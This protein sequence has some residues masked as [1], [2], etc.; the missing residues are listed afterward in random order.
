[1][2]LAT[3]GAGG[4]P[5]VRF[6]HFKGLRAN[7]FVFYTN[8]GSRKALELAANPAAA[9]AFCWLPLRRQVR[10]EGRCLQLDRATSESYFSTR[11]RE[12]Q[13]SSVAS[14]QS[15]ELVSFDV[16]EARI[17]ALRVEHAGREI[18]CPVN[19]GGIVLEAEH[20]EFWQGQAHRRHRRYRYDLYQS[21]WNLR[22]LYP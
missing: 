12:S 16:L 20:M 22:L 4:P 1:M 19:W 2:A 14:E 18:P 21:T 10:V 13:L 3:A 5:S 17:E 8:Y 6:V 15:Q 11:S 9:L 7:R